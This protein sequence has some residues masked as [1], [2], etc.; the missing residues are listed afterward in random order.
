MINSSSIE[1]AS[2]DSVIT[3]L[4]TACDSM[5]RAFS[6]RRSRCGIRLIGWAGQFLSRKREAKAREASS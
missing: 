5:R 6:R 1:L 3:M 4:F 2:F